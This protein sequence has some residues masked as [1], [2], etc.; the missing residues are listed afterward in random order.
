[1]ASPTV[2]HDIFLNNPYESHPSLTPLEAEVLW[3]YAKLAQHVKL[4]TQKTR[5]L[6]EEP[7]K[8]M[9]TRLRVLEKKMGLVLTLFKASVWGVINEQAAP[10]VSDSLDFDNSDRT[11]RLK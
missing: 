5:L 8:K 7:D 3:E 9:L 4:M 2:T 6:Q 11:I 1:M 10:D